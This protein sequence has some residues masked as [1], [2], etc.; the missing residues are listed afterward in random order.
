MQADATLLGL[1]KGDDD[2]DEEDQDD[3][4]FRA[5]LNERAG[6]DERADWA[7]LEKGDDDDD[8]DDV[9]DQDDYLFRDPVVEEGGG[10][11][12][13]PVFVA[14]DSLLQTLHCPLFIV[15]FVLFLSF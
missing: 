8:D 1:E 6:V 9:E 4:L 15:S 5:V 2:D 14:F 12:Q 10:R 13:G 7:N 11:V 3:Y